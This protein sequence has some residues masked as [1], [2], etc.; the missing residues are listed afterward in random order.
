[1]DVKEL[2]EDV[3]PSEVFAMVT[4]DPETEE[5]G[6]QYGYVLLSLP[7]EDFGRFVEMLA[8]AEERLDEEDSRSS[9]GRDRS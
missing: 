8:E 2:V 9:E 5:V 6:V 3:L 4:Y 1:M 7:R